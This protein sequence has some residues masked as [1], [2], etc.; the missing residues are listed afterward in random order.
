MRRL[1]TFLRRVFGRESRT[2][3]LLDELAADD[4]SP[5]KVNAKTQVR[6]FVIRNGNW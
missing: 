6:R 1:L 2:P 3:R 5:G 4:D